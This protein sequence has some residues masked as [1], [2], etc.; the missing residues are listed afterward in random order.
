VPD[1]ALQ[2]SWQLPEVVN[3][4]IGASTASQLGR[5]LAGLDRPIDPSLWPSLAEAMDWPAP[6]RTSTSA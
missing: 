1:A 6:L 4:T 5:S 3:V 2:Y